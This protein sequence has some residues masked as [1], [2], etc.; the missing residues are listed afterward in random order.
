VVPS[1]PGDTSETKDR[2]LEHNRELIC[3]CQDQY[4]DEL[5]EAMKCP[6]R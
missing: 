3:S 5:V 1:Q 6:E 4:K 2:L